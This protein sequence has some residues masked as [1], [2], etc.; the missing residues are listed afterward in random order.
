MWEATQE[1]H[2]KMIIIIIIIRSRNFLSP[3]SFHLY[4]SATSNT[5][6][7][8]SVEGFVD[9]AISD[10]FRVGV[11]VGK[12]LRERSSENDGD[13]RDRNNAHDSSRG[14]LGN[15]RMEDNCLEN[16]EECSGRSKKR[17]FSD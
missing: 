13:I 6:L 14:E 1:A 4:V 5:C 3:P 2:G 7:H 8:Q 10:A 11:W 9:S 17:R 15:E 12:N 16:D